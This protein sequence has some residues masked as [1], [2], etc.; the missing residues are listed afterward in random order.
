LN[1][2]NS[3]PRAFTIDTDTCRHSSTIDTDTH[4]VSV[5]VTVVIPSHVFAL[6]RR[7][8]VLQLSHM[9]G[10]AVTQ[11]LQNDVHAAYTHSNYY[12]PH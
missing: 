3:D 5:T 12:M 11:V 7:Y 10:P 9:P 6:L 4:D 8:P 1:A 2:C